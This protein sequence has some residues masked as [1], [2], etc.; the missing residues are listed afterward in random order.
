MGYIVDTRD[1]LVGIETRRES[2]NLL[3]LQRT[4]SEDQGSHS[5]HVIAYEHGTIEMTYE[6]LHRLLAVIERNPDD[7]QRR[8]GIKLLIVS[9]DE[10]SAARQEGGS[11]G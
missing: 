2:F 5:D 3:D 11:D 7:L 1:D 6:F 10:E 8:L 4:W 9:L